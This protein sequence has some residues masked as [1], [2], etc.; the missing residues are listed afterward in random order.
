VLGAGVRLSH[1]EAILRRERRVPLLEQL[2][3]LFSSRL[4][5]NRATLGGNLGT[6]S[7]IGDTPPAL[8]ALDAELT[9]MSARGTRRIALVDFFLGYRKT[10]LAQGELIASVHLPLPLPR[11]QRFYKV[12]KRVLDDISSV[13]GAF[14][15]DL[16]TEG[17]IARFR[18]AFGGVATTPIR[19]RH[20][21]DA[22]VGRPWNQATRDWLARELNGVGTPLTDHRASAAYRRAMLGKLAEK[23]WEETAPGS[24]SAA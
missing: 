10:A 1:L 9:L 2:L 6:A 22:A 11:L 18:V 16:D 12:S 19:P 3:P 8:L 21:E 5:R 7:P 14:A 17:N 20:V 23:F 4:I 24:E 13:A 15:L